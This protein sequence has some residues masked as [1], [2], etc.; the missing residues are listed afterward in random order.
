M[1][2]AIQHQGQQAVVTVDGDIVA[3]AGDALQ[4]SLLRLCKEGVT[5]LTIDLAAVT[6]IDSFGIG[7]LIAT[8]N[9]LKKGGGKLRLKQVNADITKMLRIMRLDR[10]FD[11]E[12]QS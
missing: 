10:H 8:H 11:L 3:S 1:Q 9:Q 4:K 2:F 12:G 6:L 5:D 7:S